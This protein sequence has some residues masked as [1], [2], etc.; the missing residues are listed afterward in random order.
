MVRRTETYGCIVERDEDGRVLAITVNA[1]DLEG[2][3]RSTRV[4]GTKASRVASSVHEVLREAGVTGR[5][6]SGGRPIQLA[7][8][9]GAHTEL[10]LQAVKPLRRSDRIDQVAAGVA[11]MSR[12]EASYW[13]AKTRQPGGLR[14]LRVLMTHGAA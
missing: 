1:T 12:E 7:N 14:A 9:P 2:N 3:D 5:L 8:I 13:H 6:W 4:N 10:L 11:E